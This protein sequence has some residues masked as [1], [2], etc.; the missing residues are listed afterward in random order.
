GPGACLARRGQLKLAPAEIATA[1][2]M[3]ASQS[4]V[5]QNGGHQRVLATCSFGVEGRRARSRWARAAA[6]RPGQTA[7]VHG[8][9]ADG[10]RRGTVVWCYRVATWNARGL[11]HSRTRPGPGR[12]PS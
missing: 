12:P 10:P 1:M 3:A 8:A 4:T 11:P 5:T 9:G 6:S 2:I 7:G